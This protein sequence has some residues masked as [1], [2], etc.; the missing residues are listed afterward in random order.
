MGGGA[1]VKRVVSLGLFLLLGCSS[2]TE[3]E[4]YCAATGSCLC[5]EGNC[6]VLVGNSC[7][8]GSCCSGLTCQAGTCLG[9][10]LSAPAELEVAAIAPDAGVGPASTITFTNNGIAS[11]GSLK[12][13]LGGDTNAFRVDDHCS[14][15]ILP[16]GGACNV[17][18]ALE[19]TALTTYQLSVTVRG[20]LG[21]S[22]ISVVHGTSEGELFV[23]LAFDGVPFPAWGP[24]SRFVQSSVPINTSQGS[25]QVAVQTVTLTANDHAG[26]SF[27]SWTLPD[28]GT[29]LSPSIAFQLAGTQ[30]VTA[31]FAPWLTVQT[32]AGYPIP[33]FST[34]ELVECVGTVCE[35]PVV[36]S[37]T[38][39]VNLQQ[40]RTFNGWGGACAD[41]G[42][43]LSCTLD[44]EGPTTVSYSLSL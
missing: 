36:G 43:N 8:E 12:T 6:C 29:W 20:P 18:V 34:P 21:E 16:P 33:T 42:T 28:G 10:S 7:N 25:G 22:A 44:V 9:P 13:E 26:A 35:Q 39:T 15:S 31:Q 1:P 11:S 5:T 27:E 24:P 32:P 38:L 3:L 2:N 17:E 14:G 40:F 23:G 30:R 4:S 41:A 19:P 37:E